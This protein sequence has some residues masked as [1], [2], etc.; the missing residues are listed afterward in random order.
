MQIEIEV[1]KKEKQVISI[2]TPAYFFGNYR[3]HKIT[4]TK[5][6]QVNNA[7]CYIVYKDDQYSRFNEIVEEIIKLEHSTP[8]SFESALQS[9]LKQ[10]HT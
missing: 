3:Q 1:T 6:I 7:I 4:D 10:I 9:F 5:I 2:K 8:E